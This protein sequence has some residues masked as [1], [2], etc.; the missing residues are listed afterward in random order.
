MSIKNEPPRLLYTRKDAARLL[1][2]STRSLD[3]LIGKGRLKVVRKGGLVMI[4]HAELARY[5]RINDYEPMAP[6][7]ITPRKRKRKTP[8]PAE[9][10]TA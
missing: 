1:S 5:A 4:P 8:A 7:T 10:T 3:Y 2:I 6:P 9:P